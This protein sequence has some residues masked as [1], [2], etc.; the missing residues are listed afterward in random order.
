MAYEASEPVPVVVSSAI[1]RDQ[2]W[3]LKL[4]VFLGVHVVLALLMIKFSS[5]ATAHAVLVITIGIAVAAFDS[6]AERV[7]YVA[8]YIVGA[9]ILWRMTQAEIFWETG[10]Y[11]TSAIFLIYICRNGRF[12]GP[13]LPVLYLALLIPSAFM[14]LGL[15]VDDVTGDISFNLSG[16]AAL[17]VAAWFFW[18]F[19]LSRKQLQLVVV[20]LA[21]PTIAIA[22]I[23]VHDMMANPW[24]FYGYGNG[25]NFAGSGGFG[26]NQVS[27]A[28]GLGALFLLFL[29][30]DETL[31]V[32]SRLMAALVA[33][34]LGV[35][36]ALTFSRGGVYNVAAAALLASPFL[37]KDPGT[38]VKVLV[39]VLLFLVLGNYVLL[40]RL[41]AF[42]SNA[43]AERFES[44]DTTGRSDLAW[45]DV[46]IW[47]DNP[48]LGVGPGQAE[49]ARKFDLETVAAHTE[50]T[51]L[52]AEHGALGFGALLTL[53][54]AG[55]QRIIMAQSDRSRALT[56]ALI[57]WGLFYMLHSGMRTEAPSFAFGLA[58]A[59]LLYRDRLSSINF[60]VLQPNNE[61]NAIPDCSMVQQAFRET[62][63]IAPPNH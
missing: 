41:Q 26:P 28:L 58:Y 16:P 25:S 45:S 11:A 60:I 55:L 24:I 17:M 51:R 33:L 42:T 29:T 44:V 27:D 37:L 57:G 22:V 62:M 47:Q 6:R 4:L 8:A 46:E 54:I 15:S 13:L 31:G 48:V 21:I 19:R 59:S 5:I 38:R 43:F 23:V 39:G 12:K 56:A 52:L 61:R 2:T 36:S 40:P 53:L 30:L 63:R 9:E 14:I 35:Q 10:K 18:E 3:V 20:S 34:W 7:A 32:T 50:F 1:G 49:S